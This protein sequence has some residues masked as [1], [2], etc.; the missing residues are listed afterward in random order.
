LSVEKT[1][2]YILLLS[3]KKKNLGIVN[4]CSGKSISLKYLV[5]ILIKKYKIKP[6]VEYKK[7]KLKN[8]ETENF[9][10]DNTKLTSILNT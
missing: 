9:Y 6:F 10:G 1:V 3:L 5:K 8:Y 7:I 4:L 2:K